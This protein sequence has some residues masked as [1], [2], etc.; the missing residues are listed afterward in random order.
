MKED[1][2]GQALCAG[3]RARA[4]KRPLFLIIDGSSMLSTSYYA[5]LPMEIKIQ[6]E[7]K[8]REPLY[9]KLMHA[10][11]GTYTNAVYGMSGTL[12]QLLE[13]LKP[14]YLA[15]VFDLTRNT[16]RR[17]IYPEYK[18]QRKESPEPLK[19]QFALMQELLTESGF[20]VLADSRYEADDLAG[21]IAAK[22]SKEAEIRLLTKDRD[23]LQLIDDEKNVRCWILADKEKSE[24]FR[25]RYGQCYLMG[26][27]TV[28][29]CLSNIMEFTSESVYGEKGVYPAHIPDL[30]GIEGDASDNIPGVRGV[31]SAA[32]PLIMEYGGLEGIYDAIDGCQ[33]EK[34]EKELSKFWKEYLGIKRS[35][36]KQLREQKEIA[37]KSK[38]LAQIKT[39][40][41]LEETLFDFSTCFIGVDSFN[42][43][44]KKLEIKTVA[45]SD[46]C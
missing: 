29:H 40:I 46:F 32:A 34:S 31:S 38:R 19:K 24:D 5:L 39:D 14:E 20:K 42:G 26:G 15:V 2:K 9:Q 27:F 30:K 22:F 11:D 1:E 4:E 17:E 28:P 25:N 7:E 3:T 16:F 8:D 37:F 6:K 12:V 10:A 36:L 33:D 41:K 43:W 18:A 44:M 13:E 35:P 21:T 45:L 23:Y